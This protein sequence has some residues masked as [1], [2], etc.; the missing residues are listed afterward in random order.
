WF[1]AR[2]HAGLLSLK[3]GGEL[4]VTAFVPVLEVQACFWIADS[5]Q[6]PPAPAAVPGSPRLPSRR[7][8]ESAVA[9]GRLLAKLLK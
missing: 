1:V 7:A 3:T 9:M 2:C 4:G 5:W 6:P 8:M